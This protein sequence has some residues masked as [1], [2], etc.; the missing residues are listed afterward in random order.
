MR[1]AFAMEVS[2]HKVAA[3]EHT[4]RPRPIP[5]G[6]DPSLVNHRPNGGELLTMANGEK[7]FHPDNGDA[8]WRLTHEEV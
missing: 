8:P 7:W 5:L 2:G 6:A 3:F 4:Y 1:T